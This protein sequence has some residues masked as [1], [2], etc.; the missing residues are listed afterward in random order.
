MPE[1]KPI[2]IVGDFN[3]DLFMRGNNFTRI[4]S[5]LN[6]KQVIDKPTRITPFSSTVLDLLIT[7]KKDMIVSSVVSPSPIA[8]HEMLLIVLDTVK[9]RPKLPTI[10]YRSR[11]NY[12]QDMFCNL[13]LNESSTLNDILNIDNVNTQVEIFTETFTKCL[14]VCAPVVTIELTRPAAP[15]IDDNL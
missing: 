13:L 2:F 7:S 8:D 11:K 10:T 15:W 1:K 3:D 9:P 14:V 6:L 12:S 5:N 4:I